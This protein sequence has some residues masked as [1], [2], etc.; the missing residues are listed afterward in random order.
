MGFLP[1]HF[2]AEGMALAHEDWSLIIKLGELASESGLFHHIG[3]TH[4]S[5]IQ[6]RG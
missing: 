6:I 1:P 4:V 5:V 3:T 2:D